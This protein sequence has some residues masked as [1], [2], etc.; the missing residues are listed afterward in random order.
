MSCE[1]ILQELVT[2]QKLRSEAIFELFWEKV[3]KMANE[4]GVNDPQLPSTRKIPSRFNSSGT[5]NITFP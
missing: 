5:E 1:S 4:N 2:L 3:K